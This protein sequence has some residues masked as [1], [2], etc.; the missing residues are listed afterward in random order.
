MSKNILFF[1]SGLEILLATS[2]CQ[3]NLK[4]HNEC[5]PLHLAAQLGKSSQVRKTNYYDFYADQN[6]DSKVETSRDYLDIF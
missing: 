4:D 3:L 5:T 2:G 1:P 6:H